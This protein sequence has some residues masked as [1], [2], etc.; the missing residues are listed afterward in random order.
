M[1]RNFN[2]KIKYWILSSVHFGFFFSVQKLIK[3]SVQLFKG[4]QTYC[5]MMLALWAYKT[6]PHRCCC[7]AVTKLLDDDEIFEIRYWSFLWLV[8]MTCIAFNW[9]FIFASRSTYYNAAVIAVSR[10]DWLMYIRDNLTF[11]R[12]SEISQARV[13]FLYRDLQYHVVLSSDKV[14]KR[15]CNDASNFFW[16]FEKYFEKYFLNV[17]TGHI[18]PNCGSAYILPSAIVECCIDLK[19]RYNHENHYLYFKKDEC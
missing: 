12:I 19:A 11:L 7:T 9:C 14:S 4:G 17:F 18:L 10:F 16:S 5:G 8:Q 1:I 6:F 2:N 3:F 15:R 13:C